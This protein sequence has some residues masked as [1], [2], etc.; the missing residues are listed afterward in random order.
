MV[1]RKNFSFY[2]PSDFPEKLDKVKEKDDKIKSLSRS[3]AVYYIISAM[4]DPESSYA[5]HSF[6]NK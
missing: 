3:Q 6:E 2:M 1:D 4:A 5:N